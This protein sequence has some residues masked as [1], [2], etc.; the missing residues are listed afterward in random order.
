VGQVWV[1]LVW[2]VL[3]FCEFWEKAGGR[4]RGLDIYWWFI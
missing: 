1:I 2:I 4:W 3:L